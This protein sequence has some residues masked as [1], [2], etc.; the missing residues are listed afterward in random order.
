MGVWAFVAPAHARALPD[1]G[2]KA[3]FPGRQ[4]FETQRAIT[5]FVL[6]GHSTQCVQCRVAAGVQ[7]IKI[8][9]RR[10]VD[11]FGIDHLRHVARHLQAAQLFVATQFLVEQ[12]VL[13]LDHLGF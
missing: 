6:I 4:F 5:K 2:P 13:G 3:G 12:R 9:L 8:G 1:R 11:V 7:T 10:K